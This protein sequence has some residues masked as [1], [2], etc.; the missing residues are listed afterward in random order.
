MVCMNKSISSIYP[1]I[2]NKDHAKFSKLEILKKNRNDP[3]D[4]IVNSSNDHTLEEKASFP[5][6]SCNRL[7]MTTHSSSSNNSVTI[8]KVSSDLTLEKDNTTKT[9]KAISDLDEIKFHNVLVSQ[10]NDIESITIPSASITDSEKVPDE[11]A[12]K[13]SKSKKLNVI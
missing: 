8:A 13:D 9:S 1:L 11:N 4:N 7:I 5:D 6:K 10:E 12:V 3:N 2:G